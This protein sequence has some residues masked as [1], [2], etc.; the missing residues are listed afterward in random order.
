MDYWSRLKRFSKI[1]SAFYS[2]FWRAFVK[3]RGN[4]SEATQKRA[5]LLRQTLENLG[6]VFIKFGQFL[7][8][9][10]DFMPPEYCREL[11]YLLENVPPFSS[12]E[13]IKAFKEDFNT[14]PDKLF[15]VFKTTSFAAAS[16][17]QAHEAYLESGE[18]LAVKIQRPGIKETVARDIKLM[19]ILAKIIDLLPLGPNKLA[20]MVR[21]FEEW[22]L[23]ELDY[24]TEANYT[25]EFYDR[26]DKDKTKMAVPKIYRKFCSPRILTAE[27]I[28]GITLSN[29]LLAIRNNNRDVL[30]KLEKMEFSREKT[31]EILLK[32]SLK[33][34]Y[35]D[36]FFH[37]DPHPANIIFMPNNELA[38]IDFGIVGKLD[39]KTR[40]ACLKYIRS[41]C[42]GDTD[43]AFEALVQLCNIPSAQNQI[44]LKKEHDRIVL[45]SLG[46]FK[47]HQGENDISGLKQII[48]KKLFKTLKILQKCNIVVPANTLRYFRAVSTLDSTIVE[49]N[50]RIEIDTIAENIRD[51]SIANIMKELPNLLTLEKFEDSLMRL[52]NVIEKEVS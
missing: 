49:L 21:Q 32:N 45:E 2:Y 5:F 17:G 15:S 11:F 30:D 34:I 29:I 3:T 37:A 35:L 6:S 47:N 48:G 27:F 51:I 9:R 13:V 28:E 25:E 38:Y 43:N 36:G 44:E 22:T 40:F 41:V 42:Y 20:P 19:K 10:P 52:L 14:T 1:I 26:Y 50:P 31:A 12:A 18:K 24:A 16:F 39:K 4:T 46:A 7:S 8:L 33:Q 23:E